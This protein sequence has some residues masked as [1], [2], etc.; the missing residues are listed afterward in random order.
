M[1]ER[2]SYTLQANNFFIF[3]PFLKMVSTLNE[4]NAL[5]LGANIFP[6]RVEVLFS[7]GP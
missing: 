5:P 2:N 6:V 3:C 7:E 1:P 4:R